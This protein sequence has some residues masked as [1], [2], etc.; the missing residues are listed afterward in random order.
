VK[1]EG[2]TA[3]GDMGNERPPETVQGHVKCG[4][5]TAESRRV[6][7]LLQLVPAL[8]P[9]PS[10]QPFLEHEHV[11]LVTFFGLRE[12]CVM[13][14]DRIGKEAMDALKLFFILREGDSV[15]VGMKF[16]VR[17]DCESGWTDGKVG[18]EGGMWCDRCGGYP[19][20]R[21]FL[22]GGIG[23]V[24][25][26]SAWWHSLGCALLHVQIRRWE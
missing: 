10:S 14:A 25:E 22:E 24:L 3:F 12:W 6:G 13:E 2:R 19:D 21:R 9:P 23:R 1:P 15:R 17:Q 8:R 16:D 26:R 5:I 4:I 7:V 11:S 20:P 18:D